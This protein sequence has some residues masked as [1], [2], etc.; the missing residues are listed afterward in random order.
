MGTAAAAETPPTGVYRRM[1][2]TADSICRRRLR[3]V[4]IHMPR[5]FRDLVSIH[6]LRPVTTLK[7]TLMDMQD[8]TIHRI[9]IHRHNSIIIV[10]QCLHTHRLC[11]DRRCLRHC[12]C[13]RA[14]GERVQRVT[15]RQPPQ[16]GPLPVSDGLSARQGQLNEAVKDGPAMTTPCLRGKPVRPILPRTIHGNHRSRLSVDYCLNRTNFILFNRI[17]TASSQPSA[18]RTVLVV[19]LQQGLPNPRPSLLR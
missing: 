12:R 7:H 14:R 6:R 1:A 19:K 16:C 13:K 17:K 5:L 8:I 3:R 18:A 2:T 10:T 11:L 15:R 4:N 9:T